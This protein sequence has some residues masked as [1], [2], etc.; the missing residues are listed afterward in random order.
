MITLI[1]TLQKTFSTIIFLLITGTIIL[2]G[3]SQTSSKSASA[4]DLNK[5][6]QCPRVVNEQV[7]DNSYNNYY[8]TYSYN[9][10]NY[11]YNPYQQICDPLSAILKCTASECSDG[12][13][14]DQS[15]YKVAFDCQNNYNNYTQPFYGC[16]EKNDPTNPSFFYNNSQYSSCYYS[17]NCDVR[18]SYEEYARCLSIDCHAIAI[19]ALQVE[20]NKNAQYA[21]IPSELSNIIGYRNDIPTSVESTTETKTLF[22]GRAYTTVTTY[23]KGGNTILASYQYTVDDN[24]V[25]ISDVA[26]PSFSSSFAV[27]SVEK[28]NVSCYDSPTFQNQYYFQ[29]NYIT[30]T[31]FRC[32][33]NFTVSFKNP[34]GDNS[35]TLNVPLLIEYSPTGQY[36]S[37]LNSF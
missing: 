10:A 19:K 35:K 26:T 31:P 12:F 6:A 24:G 16:P 17:Q 3:F 18:P 7:Y 29:D 30:R 15:N 25:V 2:L 11:Q 23:I 21:Y 33:S 28:S 1:K 32:Q 34:D 8:G 9:Y 4:I 5:L 27:T 36:T 13:N 14:P 22:G 20:V 37:I